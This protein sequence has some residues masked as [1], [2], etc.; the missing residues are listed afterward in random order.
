MG[1]MASILTVRLCVTSRSLRTPTPVLR[2]MLG[3]LTPLTAPRNTSMPLVQRNLSFSRKRGFSEYEEHLQSGGGSA[4]Y[5]TQTIKLSFRS[6]PTRRYK[7]PQR[8]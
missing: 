7:G 5:Y 3:F 8:W 6:T 2:L 1:L 4:T